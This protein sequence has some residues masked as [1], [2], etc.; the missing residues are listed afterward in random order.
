[1]RKLSTGK[2][3]KEGGNY[4]LVPASFLF[5]IRYVLAVPLEGTGGEERKKSL[6]ERREE[7]GCH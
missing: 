7:N 1:M 4:K 6:K 2:K 5:I 3:G